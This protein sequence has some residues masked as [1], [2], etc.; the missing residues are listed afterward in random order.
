MDDNLNIILLRQKYVNYNINC[1]TSD[2]YYYFFMLIIFM[3]MLSVFLNPLLICFLNFLSL[4]I[5]KLITVDLFKRLT[6]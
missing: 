6:I 2:I 5:S 1:F 4:L 3:Y